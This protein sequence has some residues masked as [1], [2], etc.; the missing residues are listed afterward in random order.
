MGVDVTLIAINFQLIS[1]PFGDKVIAAGW[2]GNTAI[3]AAMLPWGRGQEGASETPASRADA[4][5]LKERTAFCKSLQNIPVQKIQF[6][7]KA[8]KLSSEDAWCKNKPQ[9]AWRECSVALLLLISSKGKYNLSP[10]YHLKFAVCL[11]VP[12]IHCLAVTSEKVIIRLNVKI[13]Y[14]SR[15]Q[16]LKNKWIW[17]NITHRCLIKLIQF[18]WFWKTNSIHF[19]FHC[20]IFNQ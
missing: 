4:P 10:N 20:A 18:S 7:L 14:T 15:R 2:W 11:F 17:M 6:Y 13:T 3:E 1:V 5:G 12:S 8:R 19:V 9:R 16:W